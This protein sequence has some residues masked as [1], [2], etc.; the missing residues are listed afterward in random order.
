MLDT[1][2][3]TSEYHGI[4][5]SPD[6]APFIEQRLADALATIEGI[7]QNNRRI[8]V[9][10]IELRIPEYNG[11]QFTWSADASIAAFV[12]KMQHYARWKHTELHKGKRQKD[13]PVIDAIWQMACSPTGKPYCRVMLLLNHA[14]YHVQSTG[15]DPANTLQFRARLAWT[16]VMR[17]PQQSSSAYIRFPQNGLMTIENSAEGL[18][19]V[20]A[21]ASALCGVPSDAN[22]QVFMSFGTT[23]YSSRNGMLG[24]MNS[25]SS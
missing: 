12:K 9:A 4:P 11:F 14:A 16:K 21:K 18:C 17:I 3:Y 1:I 23:R 5:L 10:C 22:G 2:T 13:R 25:S 19:Q 15:F 7:M 6:H 24:I 20:F 8:T